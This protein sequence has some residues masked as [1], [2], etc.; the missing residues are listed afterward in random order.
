MV[1][2]KNT[3]NAA[4]KTARQKTDFQEI[5]GCSMGFGVLFVG[6]F[7][8]INI[9]Y[10]SFTDVIAAVLMLTALS[11]LSRF[12]R[13]MKVSYILDGVF[14]FVALGEFLL[15]ICEM[16]SIFD[17]SGVLA[18]LLPLRY[19]LVGAMSVSLL[20][21]IRSLANEV[22]LEKL[23][24]K[25]LLSLSL[26]A[27]V[28]FL[29]ALLEI[30]PLFENTSVSDTGLVA[31]IVLLFTLVSV[32]VMLVRIYTAYMR[33]CM[34]EDVDMEEKPSRFAFIN[35][36]REKK[37]RRAAEEAEELKRL[38]LEKQKRKKK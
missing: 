25:C 29:S 16:F 32:C 14:A 5:G 23:A 18:V 38:R 30:T 6:Y 27:L 37:A 26:P 7:F 13:P 17:P 33:I 31:L 22:G 15:A 21:G 12:N 9:T 28:Y 24:N 10:F 4:V 8:L 2:V 1:A 11:S 19:L 36:Y 20:L 35:R 3:K 34:P